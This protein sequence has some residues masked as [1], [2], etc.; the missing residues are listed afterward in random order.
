MT[1][2]EQSIDIDVPVEMAYGEWT[3]FERFPEFMDGVQE[4]TQVDD[5]HLRWVADIGGQRESWDALITANEPPERIAWRSTSGHQNSGL[6]TFEP[7]D[8]S[9]T[10]VT[11]QIEHEPAGVVQSVGSALHLDERRVRAD[12]ERFKEQ[13]E[14]QQRQQRGWTRGAP[15]S[16]LDD[17]IIRPS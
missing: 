12:L 3:Q 11:V 13:I 2:I 10:R 1:R 14:S 5:T 8:E 6:V 16:D 9:G 7:T 15:R 17:G 4:V